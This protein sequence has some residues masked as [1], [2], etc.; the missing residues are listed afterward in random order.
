[1]KSIKAFLFQIFMMA[2]LFPAMILSVT[3]L[4]WLE[5][6]NVDARFLPQQRERRIVVDRGGE[7]TEMDL[8]EYVTQVV[9]AE[10][11]AEFEP[12]ALKA[13]AVAAR[14]FAWKAHTTGGK[15]ADG[16]VCTNAACCQGFITEENFV[17]YYGTN[18]E[19]EKIT[20]AVTA[21]AG[22]V[23][24]YNGQLIEAAYFSSA[25]GNT[26]D[27]LAVWGGDYPYLTAKES[28][29]ESDQGEQTQAFSA[30]FLENTLN[31]RLEGAPDT[32]FHDWEYTA[33]GGVASVG[34]GNRVFTGITLRKLLCL[35]S[36][37]FSVTMENDVVFF[38]TRGYGHR[39]GMSQYGAN[40]M[41]KAGKT[42][43]E[44]LQYYY[45]GTDL[46]SISEL[47]ENDPPES[48]G[49]THNFQK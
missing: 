49:N 29:E 39:V 45:T 28:P 13:Q 46:V 21:T 31:T 42:W 1:M 37:A 12:D 14:T 33:G 24:T 23:I 5:E 30:A 36:T 6:D 26:E 34:I 7:K 4:S 44:I 41:A 43:E 9:L 32:W 22:M 3:Q 40:A 27:A 11:P 35:R 10:M 2:F 16:S 47:E 8:E 48:T 19:L 20:A 17:N 38:H 25:G 15:H 18:E